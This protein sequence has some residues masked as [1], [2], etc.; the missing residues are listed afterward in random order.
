M[1][2]LLVEDES[3]VALAICRL[4]ERNRHVVDE[5]ESLQIAKA[6]MRDNVYELVLLDRR[7]PDGDGLELISFAKDKGMQTRFLVLS[8]LSDLE[9]RVEGLDLGA[10]DYLVKPFEPDE[11]LAR[12]RAAERRPIPDVARVL[13]VGNLR[14]NCDTRNFRISGETTVLPRR[15]LIVISSLMR[16]AGGVVS[17]DALESALYGFDEA[18]QSNALEAH[19]SRLRKKFTEHDARVEI[20]TIR[21]VGYMLREL[22]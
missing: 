19:I 11:L 6:A 14:L 20:H 15:E 8:A 5:A 2:I 16:N 7:L 21:G 10:D 4:L 17:R 18:V 12:I 1:K 3:G 9:D 13:E 22:H